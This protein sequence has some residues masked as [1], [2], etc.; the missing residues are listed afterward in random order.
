ME[1]INSETD[2]SAFSAEEIAR[3][4]EANLK[5]GLSDEEAATRL[6]KF[7]PNELS[8]TEKRS[9]WRLI[10]DQLNSPIV[11][12]LLVAAGISFFF[13]EYLNAIA[14]LIVI[15]INTAVGFI[16]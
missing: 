14:I 11:Y 13:Q 15:V 5:T 1:S 16:M 7:G 6:E 12:L 10:W 4:L 8:E 3:K 2:L 9:L